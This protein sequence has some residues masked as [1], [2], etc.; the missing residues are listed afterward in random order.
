M[1]SEPPL[2]RP[3]KLEAVHRALERKL[4]EQRR[5]RWQRRREKLLRFWRGLFGR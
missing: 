5:A 1:E 2:I 3:E 4:E